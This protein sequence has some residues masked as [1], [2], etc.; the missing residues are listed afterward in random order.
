MPMAPKRVCAEMGCGALVEKGRCAKHRREREDRRGSSTQRGYGIRWQRGRLPVLKDFGQRQVEQG[1]P[2]PPLVVNGRNTG[3]LG[4][5]CVRCLKGGQ[6]TPANSID[7][8]RPKALGGSDD[9]ENYQPL[10]RTCNS[11]K[12]VRV[13]D[14]R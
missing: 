10:C 5:W 12:G 14:Y 13:E 2:I 7:H 8:I 4:A 1:H 11:A 3:A 9:P 6:Y